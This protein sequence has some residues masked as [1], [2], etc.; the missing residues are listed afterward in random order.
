MANRSSASSITIVSLIHKLSLSLVILLT[1]SAPSLAGLKEATINGRP[2]I[3]TD[4]VTLRIK[5]KDDRDRPAIALTEENFK[6][7]IDN[8]PLK[9]APKDWKSPKEVTP[10]PAWIVV[11]ID[12][13]GSMRNPDS[14]GKSKMKGALEAI[15]QFKETLTKRSENLPLE[16]IPRLAIVPFGEGGGKGESSCKGFPVDNESLDKFFPA[17]DFKLQNHLDYLSGLTPCASTNLYEPLSKALKMLGNSKDPRF[18]P[19]NVDLQKQPRLSV[20]L[21]S[22]G[23]QNTADEQGAFENLKSLLKRNQQVMVHTLGYGLNLEELG[24]KYNLKK[25]ATRGDVWSGCN[26]DAKKAPAGK[27]C[28]EEFVDQTRLQEIAQLSGGVSEFSADAQAVSE[29]LDLFLDALIGEYEITFT[30]PVAERGSKHEAKVV[31]QSGPT[32]I[33]SAPQPYTIT[34]FGRSVSGP[35]RMGVFAL[36][37]L[38]LAAGGALPFWLW[39]KSLKEEG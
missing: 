31:V 5:V 17:T 10:P 37:L 34:V 2:T 25:A 24:R 29:K 12:M 14:R 11:L 3:D 7:L 27:V 32:S 39:S 26:G 36:T 4:R 16:Y 22:D 6:L 23:Y 18:Y 21:L 33:T 15:G 20:I 30:Q 1:S 9:F 8:E 19:E 13:S 38:A 35:I 28:D